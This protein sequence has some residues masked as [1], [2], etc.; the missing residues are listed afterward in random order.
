[1]PAMSSAQQAAF[2]SANSGGSVIQGSDVQT[3]V[4]GILGTLTLIWFCWVCMSAYQSLRRP[5]ATVAD[6]GGSVA[7]AAFVMIVI[8]ALLTS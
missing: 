6:A 7:R 1:M 3:M 2:Q 5:G 8:L 4:V